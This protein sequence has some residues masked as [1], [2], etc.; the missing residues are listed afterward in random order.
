M[1]GHEVYVV[2]CPALCYLHAHSW[3]SQNLR[4]PDAYSVFFP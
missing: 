4:A 3:E 2:R 1:L